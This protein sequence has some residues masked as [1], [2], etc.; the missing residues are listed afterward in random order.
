MF[1]AFQNELKFSITDKLLGKIFQDYKPLIKKHI[2]L[3]IWLRMSILLLS[4]C[5][6][7]RLETFEN[8]VHLTKLSIEGK[9]IILKAI[10]TL[11]NIVKICKYL[12]NHMYFVTNHASSYLSVHNEHIQLASCQRHSNMRLN[13]YPIQEDSI[14]NAV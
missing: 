4:V 1:T 12:L 14:E 7:T 3:L 13:N 10:K 9:R 2:S 5:L 8:K 6:D 11:I